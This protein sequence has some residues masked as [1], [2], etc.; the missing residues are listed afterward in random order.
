MPFRRCYSYLLE[1]PLYT[2]ARMQLFMNITPYTV[3]SIETLLFG[4]DNLTDENNLIVFR[5]VHKYIHH[6]KRFGWYD[7][8]LCTQ[9][10][11]GIIHLHS[12]PFPPFFPPLLFIKYIMYTFIIYVTCCYFHI[13]VYNNI[14][15]WSG[16]TK[17]I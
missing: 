2:N 17:L 16:C 9:D 3:I 6:A 1:C 12:V 10:A 14:I 13:Y 15:V 4:S 8:K 7:I 5:N 11:T